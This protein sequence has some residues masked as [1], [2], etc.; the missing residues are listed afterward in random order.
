MIANRCEDCGNAH[1]KEL[2]CLPVSVG[3]PGEAAVSLP[4]KSPSQWASKNPTTTVALDINDK[5]RTKRPYVNRDD[6]NRKPV[7]LSSSMG[8][9]KIHDN[10]YVLLMPLHKFIDSC[11]EDETIHRAIV[12]KLMEETLEVLSDDT[13][14]SEPT[15]SHIAHLVNPTDPREIAA[16]TYFNGQITDGVGP[17]L[18][19]ECDNCK[20]HCAASSFTDISYLHKQDTGRIAAV[21]DM[22]LKLNKGHD[23]YREFHPG[24]MNNPRF[25]A[26]EDEKARCRLRQADR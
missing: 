12:L 6:E 20:A 3:E 9:V 19:F 8:S 24:P 14:E 5:G 26:S 11:F 15:P 18:K 13:E 25:Q 2:G 23:G 22:C 21:C 1:R 17:P 4:F 10:V 16:A 7:K